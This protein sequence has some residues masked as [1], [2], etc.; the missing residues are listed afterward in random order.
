[1][2][3]LYVRRALT[4]LKTHLGGG[5]VEQPNSM[6]VEARMKSQR[7]H[8]APGTRE[9]GIKVDSLIDGMKPWLKIRVEV[10]FYTINQDFRLN[11]N[12]TCSISPSQSIDH[13]HIS[14]WERSVGI[15]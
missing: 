14:H 6:R 7:P 12:F 10:V 5:F 9:F 4:R 13:T 15:L 11:Y 1:M 8:Q 3:K 2:L